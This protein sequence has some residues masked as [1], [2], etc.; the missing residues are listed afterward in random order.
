MRK[1][2]GQHTRLT[3]MGFMIVILLGQWIAD[4]LGHPV[5]TDIV[6]KAE[7]L[8]ALL[9]AS[10]TFAPLRSQKSTEETADE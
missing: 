5:P 2:T 6:T 3:I 1:P 9:L 7:A 8:L 10:D 4:I